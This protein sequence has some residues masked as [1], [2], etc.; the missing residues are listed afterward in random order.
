M[1]EQVMDIVSMHVRMCDMIILIKKKLKKNHIF[2]TDES[3]V[4]PKEFTYK[5]HITNDDTNL[6]WSHTTCYLFNDIFNN[7][8]KPIKISSNY[9]LANFT[10]DLAKLKRTLNN[11][12]TKGYL[13]KY[14]VI[15]DDDDIFTTIKIARNHV[16]EL[17]RLIDDYIKDDIMSEEEDE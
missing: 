3:L 13:G 10:E 5:L 17:I 14:S 9:T 12:I 16:C 2:S 7:G 8:Y 4:A 15:D 11:M 1:N 6:S